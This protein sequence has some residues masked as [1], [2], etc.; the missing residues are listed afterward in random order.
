MYFELR[1]QPYRYGGTN[2]WYGM[3]LGSPG[4]TGDRERLTRELDTL[5]ALGMTNLRVLAGSELSYLHRTL[6]PAVQSR[7]GEYN[8]TLLQGLDFLLDEMRKR[9]MRAVVFFSNYWEWSGGFSQYVTWGDGNER[10]VDPE[11]P[12]QGWPAFMDYSASFYKHD[13]AQR[14]YRQFV[15]SVVGRRNSVNG[16]YYRDDPTIMAWQLANEPRPG[17]LGDRGEGNLPSFLAWVDSTAR[18]IKSLDTNHLVCTGSEG[19]IGTLQNESYFVKAH[20]TPAV[21]YLT[22]HLWPYNWQWFDPKHAV[23]SLDSATQK[24]TDY[25]RSHMAIAR[26]MGKPITLEEFGLPRDNASNSAGASSVARERYFNSILNMIS[27]SAEA[28]GALVGWNVW[29]WGGDGTGRS[30]DFRWRPGDD[31]AGDPPHEPQGINSIF[32]G[33]VGTKEILSRFAWRMRR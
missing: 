31:F 8:D 32:N 13:G 21:D 30:E 16:L 20:A 12:A 15:K 14:L 6:T 11:D 27:D 4:P 3:Y 25:I 10:G 1:G 29:A 19:S 18:F 28:G 2:F 9:D 23:G 26:S 24:A 5:A 7:P 33:D 22:L 17:T